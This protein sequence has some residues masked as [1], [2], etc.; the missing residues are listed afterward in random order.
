MT[1]LIKPGSA[2]RLTLDGGSGHYTNLDGELAIGILLQNG[3]ILF[4]NA[5][6]TN[7]SEEAR[8]AALAI[9]QQQL[10]KLLI[11]YKTEQNNGD[12]KDDST[13]KVTEVVF[14]GNVAWQKL[15]NSQPP[16]YPTAPS[17]FVTTDKPC[18]IKITQDKDKHL[19]IT[20]SP[21]FT[22]DEETASEIKNIKQCFE[23][24]HAAAIDHFH[25][26]NTATPD[27]KNTAT[28]DAKG[29][30]TLPPTTVTQHFPENTTAPDT[31]GKKHLPPEVQKLW[32]TFDYLLNYLEWL[33]SSSRPDVWYPP[34]GQ[35]DKDYVPLH[36]EQF[37]KS[38]T[39]DD[40]P[41]QIKINICLTFLVKFIQAYISLHLDNSAK[42]DLYKKSAGASTCLAYL[43]KLAED[44]L[45]ISADTKNTVARQKFLDYL[46]V[47]DPAFCF[48]KRMESSL[49]LAVSEQ[50]SLVD[51]W[52]E[53]ITKNNLPKDN[54]LITLLK[55]TV[56]S[57]A[58]STKSKTYSTE[59]NTGEIT[60]H[61]IGGYTPVEIV[62]YIISALNPTIN[63]QHLINTIRS[64]DD[65]TMFTEL[66]WKSIF[67]LLAFKLSPQDILALQQAIRTVE[68]KK[69]NVM[70][71]MS[72]RGLGS[73]IVSEDS[74][75]ITQLR[76]QLY[77]L[78]DLVKTPAVH[79]LHH[80]TQKNWQ[81]IILLTNTLTTSDQEIITTC[82][83]DKD[84]S[85]L[86]FALTDALSI[87]NKHKSVA[88][89]KL[90]D[91]K[92]LEGEKLTRVKFRN[93]MATRAANSNS[94]LPKI[95]SNLN[96]IKVLVAKKASLFTPNK[97][98]EKPFNMALVA[99]QQTPREELFELIKAMYQFSAPTDRAEIIKQ[100]NT[101]NL[102]AKAAELE[103]SKDEEILLSL[104]KQN[105]F[106]VIIAFLNCERKK[107]LDKATLQTVL[108]AATCACHPQAVKELCRCGADPFE[109]D[110]SGNTSFVLACE[111][112]PTSKDD[113]SVTRENQAKRT[114]VLTTL[115]NACKDC[116]A[117]VL[118]LAQA[119]Q[120]TAINE[121]YTHNNKPITT[122]KKEG[123]VTALHLAI[124]A[125]NDKDIKPAN[126]LQIEAATTAICRG[127]NDKR[128]T[129]ANDAEKSATKL[130]LQSALDK[131]K[132]TLPIAKTILLHNSPLL[133]YNQIVTTIKN[134]LA[135]K[136]LDLQFLKELVPVQINIKDKR[137]IALQVFYNLVEN[138]TNP[139]F[140]MSY[141]KELEALFKTKALPY[142]QERQ[143]NGKCSWNYHTWENQKT[144][145]TWA[146]MMKIAKQKIMQHALDNK[147]N[148][149]K[150][151]P[152]AHAFLNKRRK[153][154]SISAS[155]YYTFR[156]TRFESHSL[157]IL[158]TATTD[159]RK[160][161]MTLNK[162]REENKCFK[163]Q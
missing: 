41:V 130:A 125:Y 59:T 72:G 163:I 143:R 145:Y 144:T 89:P 131:S 47:T 108:T 22:I 137:K 28:P 17:K 55:L 58:Y 95:K 94:V 61:L 84:D 118:N 99:Y 60:Y 141:V 32:N 42:L 12:S 64:D 14:V 148:L 3:M 122:L 113:K 134:L 121:F 152:E 37:F 68:A 103:T 87:I 35:N 23:K 48:D 88:V 54:D 126:Q 74:P 51:L 39:K 133:T 112:E 147:L 6:P 107:P 115:A 92:G 156:Y 82:K 65:A 62:N 33:C 136:K 155:I 75:V 151:F 46:N 71:G 34:S 142:L 139:N 63:I 70:A 138:T 135:A 96:C 31:K 19:A 67:D 97:K 83:N 57:K 25:K 9:A 90:E 114:A 18:H 91:E 158:K 162:E 98:G 13:T 140:V 56:Q 79:A 20:Q 76:T 21:I 27:A 132:T 149:E 81:A 127:L 30:H 8:K 26:K 123:S 110:K 66:E 128:P 73:G 117:T 52:Q 5:K 146:R 1:V 109:A 24:I 4:A 111:N 7:D 44:K 150:D 104:A 50:L 78:G 157:S 116:P 106:D 154:Q 38:L 153:E 40:E 105:E 10:E 43:E 129:S 160:A 53:V 93:E 85:V 77:L 86:H 11:A 102:N 16:L 161:K 36:M 69:N 159:E 124:D 49:N 100:L 45:T 2:V 15:T 29:E 120:W 80:A 119:K 101:A